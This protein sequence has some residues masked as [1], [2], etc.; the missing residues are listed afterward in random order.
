MFFKITHHNDLPPYM[1]NKVDE[2]I[3]EALGN[4]PEKHHTNLILAEKS[5]FIKKMVRLRR[6]L[7]TLPIQDIKTII[8]SLFWS[9]E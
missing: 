4:W 5:Y 6:I 9:G 2:A 3:K 8:D 1:R 7:P